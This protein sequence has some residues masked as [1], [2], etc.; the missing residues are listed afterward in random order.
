MF[1]TMVFHHPRPEH[2]GAFRAFM[3]EIITG[4]AGTE[5]L[6]S[7]ESYLN[8]ADSTLVALARWESADDAQAGIPKLMSISHRRPEWTDLPDEMFQLAGA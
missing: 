6:V 4:M 8:P 3:S 5:G 2:H 7:F 1:V